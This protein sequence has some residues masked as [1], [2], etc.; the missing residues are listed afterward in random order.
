MSYDLKNLT[1]NERR[2][3]AARVTE[4]IA[5]IRKEGND[6]SQS[7][8][9]KEIVNKEFDAAAAAAAKAAHEKMEKQIADR[10]EAMEK[11]FSEISNFNIGNG[12]YDGNLTGRIDYG[13]V[14]VNLSDKMNP[15]SFSG[16][17]MMTGKV[18]RSYHSESV[19]HKIQVLQKL[20]DQA[21][22]VG[23]LLSK[24]LEIPYAQAVFHSKTFGLIREMLKG[25]TEL[26]KAVNTSTTAQGAELIPTGMS[27]RILERVDL[28]N[29]AFGL[30]EAI[31]MPTNPYEHPVNTGDTQ[32]YSITENTTDNP[33]LA[34]NA[35]TASTPPTGNFVFS[36]KGLGVRVRVSYR[37]LEDAI[38]NL[39]P[40]I[41][42][43]MFKG[44]N[45]GQDDAIINGDDSAT[46]Q[47]SDT[48]AGSA[49]LP[50]KL[51]KGLRYYG[52]N[53][54][55]GGVD[56]SNGDPSLALMQQVMLESNKYAA[57]PSDQAWMMGAKVYTKARTTDGLKVL[58]LND[59]GPQAT[60]L[61][62]ELGQWEGS[63]IVPA[64][65]CRENLN[66]S[67]VYD[68]TTTDRGTIKYVHRPGFKIGLLGQV[69]LET[70]RDIE[71]QQQVLVASRW[72][73]FKSPWDPTNA[74]YPFVSIGYNVKTT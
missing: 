17:M 55:A 3:L 22:I 13:K 74:A 62:G 14:G 5:E 51:W 53:A 9:V 46:H 49:K 21:Y 71:N 35:V 54:A 19:A 50:A 7:G 70:D 10:F 43:E 72:F 38:I 2:Q 1:E 40:Y 39:I 16:K 58:S 18:L 65:Y 25:D 24:S 73:Q 59:Y 69:L 31:N 26:A 42:D 56:F 61:T 4:F 52:L 8:E 30:F 47:D 32:V 20:Q 41:E 66:A 33:T 37:A 48:H 28:M 63:P 15:F 12:L 36:A 64:K 11:K 45:D 34:S 60:V 44:M 23:K 29:V 57:V 27:G 67:G 6:P 68:G